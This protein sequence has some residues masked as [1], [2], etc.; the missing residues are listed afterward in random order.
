[1]KL[2]LAGLLLVAAGFAGGAFAR[3]DKDPVP[4]KRRAFIVTDVMQTATRKGELPY[5]TSEHLDEAMARLE[6]D[7]W[8]VDG[9]S[10]DTER[11]VLLCRAE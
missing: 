4:S 10:F 7:G 11:A 5:W 8:I 2:V 3:L 9:I 1:M 6:K